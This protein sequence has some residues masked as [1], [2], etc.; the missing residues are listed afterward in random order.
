V[1]ALVDG[2]IDGFEILTV[3]GKGSKQMAYNG[4]SLITPNILWLGV[5][6]S[7]SKNYDIPEKCMKSLSDKELKYLGRLV[8]K[9][10]VREHDGWMKELNIMLKTKQ[11]I[12]IQATNVKWLVETYLPTK[13][14]SSDWLK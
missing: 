7:D 12:D 11:K 4:E 5:R 8:K 3:Y 6:P 10:R 14:K 9:P 13:L 2:D 1:L